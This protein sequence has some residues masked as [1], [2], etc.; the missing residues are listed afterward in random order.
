MNVKIDTEIRAAYSEAI[1][2]GLNILHG[3]A[4][5]EFGS[6]YKLLGVDPIAAVILKNDKFPKQDQINDEFL[7]NPGFIKAA[8]E[9][10]KVDPSWIY[11]FFMGYDRSYQI[12]IVQEKEKKETK[13]D[14]SN[15][16]IS[17]YKEFVSSKK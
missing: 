9:I 10:L 13:D 6:E 1:S 16:G 11:R 14:V 4:W 12:M 5:C 2:K 7:S 17:L 3:S 8:C 15:Y